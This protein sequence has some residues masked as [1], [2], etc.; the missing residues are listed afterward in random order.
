MCKHPLKAF[1]I[2]WN[3][4]TGKPKYKI[5]SYK[6]DHLE[7]IR[8]S[9]DVCEGSFVSPYAKKVYREWIEI[10][11]GKCI[12]CRLQY[13]RQWADRCVY[14]AMYY[15]EDQCWFCTL[16]Y[17]NENIV[18]VNSEY[19][20][21]TLVKKHFQ[22]FMKRLRDHEYRK[23]GN[24]IRFYACGEYGSK[25]FRPHYHVIIFGIQ[26]RP[27]SLMEWTVSKSGKRQ[28]RSCYLEDI[29]ERGICTVSPMSWDTAAYTAR[30]TLKKAFK[31]YSKELYEV[32][33][34]EPEFVLMSRKP[35]IGYQFYEDNKKDIYKFDQIIQRSPDGGR[36][37]K[38]PRYFDNRLQA[39]NPE[40][41]NLIK[42]NR[43]ECA[44]HAKI[45]K[46]R[47]TDKTYEELL[48]VEEEAM[49]SRI[50]AL[51]RDLE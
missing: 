5:V 50:K 27:D 29:W 23:N 36:K 47:L 32:N 41:Y 33:G 11:C 24:R 18:D 13:S 8:D 21:G 49:L 30:Y 31:E 14:E 15:P 37:T 48:T 20:P 45:A 26:F 19:L 17:N 42:S 28:W 51:K 34:L 35:G 25:T 3:T 16:T 12:E 46:L 4:E 10:P 44:E 38:P 40:L 43:K 1:Q 22:D 2:G 6:T 7:Q 39:E 9:I